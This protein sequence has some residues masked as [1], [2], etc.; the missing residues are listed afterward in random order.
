MDNLVDPRMKWYEENIEGLK[1]AADSLVG[2]LNDFTENWLVKD[3]GLLTQDAWERFKKAHPYYVPFQ[4]I[5][6]E[7]EGVHGSGGAK[8]GYANQ[9]YQTK[10][11]L[12]HR[13]KSLTRWKA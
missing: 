7:S 8:R 5:M 3:N 11:R 4:R 13:G 2:W 12:V 9:P 6:T 1:E 10:R